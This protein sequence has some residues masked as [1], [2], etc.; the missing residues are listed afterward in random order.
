MLDDGSVLEQARRGDEAAWRHLYES[1]A[2]MV[3]RLALRIVGDR[4]A[5]L[6]VLQETYM[7][8]ARALGG[9]RG[10]AKF[11]SWIARIAINEART[12]LRK[13]ARRRE[14]SLEVLPGRADGGLPVDE[15]VA[16]AD[17]ARRALELARTLPDR[18]RDAVI[19]R[20][21]EGYSYREI[22]EMLGTSEGSVRVSYH[23]GM[24]K[25]REWLADFATERSDTRGGEEKRRTDHSERRNEAI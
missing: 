1:H 8:A 17:L 9:F 22:A 5:A 18:Q 3:F 15:K 11:R 19:L 12:W 2:D 14:V 16:R 24:A 25:L 21:T 6:D 20:T 7:R 13:K 23:H 10:D 4:E